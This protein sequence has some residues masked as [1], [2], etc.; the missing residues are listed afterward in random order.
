M[1]TI[2]TTGHGAIKHI[3]VGGEIADIGCPPNSIFR[4]AIPSWRQ[5]RGRAY[6]VGAWDRG[7]MISEFGKGYTLGL[8]TPTVAPTL[9]LGAAGLVKSAGTIYYYS[10]IHKVYNIVMDESD[11]S[12]PSATVT[13]TGHHLSVSAV[14]AS[15]P[16]DRKA[17]HWRAYRSDNGGTPRKVS[18]VLIGTTTLDDNTPTLSLGTEADLVNRGVVP[19]NVRYNE[20]YGERMWYAG[21]KAHP[22]RIYYSKIGEPQSVA[23]DNYLA[24][25]EGEAVRGLRRNRDQLIVGCAGCFYAIQVRGTS[26]VIEKITP[27]IGLLSHHGMVDIHG[28]LWFPA[29]EGTYVYDGTFKLVSRE[30]WHLYRQEY[31]ATSESFHQ[32]QAIHDVYRKIYKLLYRKAPAAVAQSRYFCGNYADF[33]PEVASTQNSQPDWTMDFRG[34][35]DSAMG[36]VSFG[37]GESQLMTGSCDGQ[38]RIENNE[39]DAD[40]DGDSYQKAL[41]LQTGCTLLELPAGG[42]E[43]D[44]ST[45]TTF[46]AY[47]QSENTGWTLRLVGGDEDAINGA[48]AGT[49]LDNTAL[50]WKDDVAASSQTAAVAKTVHFF[51]PE[52]VSGRGLVVQVYAAAPVRLSFRGFGLNN[53][54][55]P[56][57]RPATAAVPTAI[58]QT[59]TT[60]VNTPLAVTLNG[61]DPNGGSVTTA[62]ATSPAHGVLTGTLPNLTYT[63]TAAYTGADS[64]TFTVTDDGTGHAGATYT[65]A[66]ATISI[67]VTP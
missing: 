12:P 41:T 48:T 61:T 3:R 22:D 20:V 51:A 39:D 32:M 14:P 56:A 57:T 54:P 42:S 2:A 7:V 43:E 40:D 5:Y 58:A 62:V 13:P 30:I 4:N 8:N 46:W 65:S 15:F 34:R 6:G 52:Q 19:S 36:L 53:G 21:S 63:P 67:T 26:F 25:R 18:D 9:A 11:L 10:L 47:V 50:W 45:V 1:P 29:R 23:E 27:T 64:F 59:L 55:G 33:E 31:Q 60:P 16:A 37:D 66:A 17:T 49:L 24:T 38:I 28:R 35:R 44:G